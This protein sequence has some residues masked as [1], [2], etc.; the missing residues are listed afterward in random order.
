MSNWLKGKKKSKSPANDEFAEQIEKYLE[1][2]RKLPADEP[3]VDQAI[4]EARMEPYEV[5]FT[6]YLFYLK[7][8]RDLSNLYIYIYIYLMVD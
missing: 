7:L 5:Q 1:H 4:N 2:V 6:F 3:R 8:I